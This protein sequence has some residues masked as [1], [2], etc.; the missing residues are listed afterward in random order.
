MAVGTGGMYNFSASPIT[1]PSL[2]FQPG[3]SDWAPGTI[4]LRV[5]NTTGA[6][7]TSFDVAY[8]LY[9]RNDQPRANSFN[10]S[11]SSDNSTYTSVSALDYSSA[12]ALD[13]LGFVLNNRSTTITGL[14][15]ANNAYFYI[16][17]SGADVSGSGSRDEFALD[18]IVVTGYAPPATPTITSFSSS[19]GCVGSSLTINGT[20]LSGASVVTIGGTAATITG[21]TATTVTVTVG[22]GTTGVVVVTC[23]AG[24]VS[25]SGG[26]AIL[27]SFN[28][29][30]PP[31][32]EV[33]R[34][35]AHRVSQ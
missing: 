35:S 10:F 27:L 26:W 15:I 7:I 30:Q 25:S 3:G 4:T 17:W 2:G 14:S 9:V 33:H 24:V 19:N 1:A 29:L 16:R 34:R 12:A 22:S 6:D 32:W 8:K 21:N 11:Y 28:L 31:R 20:N 18:D 13:A 23:T 5:Q